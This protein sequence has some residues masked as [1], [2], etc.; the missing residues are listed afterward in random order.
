MCDRMGS[1]SLVHGDT[2]CGF[3]TDRG[4][5]ELSWWGYVARP[6]GVSYD[7]SGTI[8]YANDDVQ[9]RKKWGTEGDVEINNVKER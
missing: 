8:S 3:S 7:H 1:R 6:L 5:P 9:R 2:C 4:T